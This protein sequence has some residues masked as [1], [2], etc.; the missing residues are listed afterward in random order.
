MATIYQLFGCLP[1]LLLPLLLPKLMTI[2]PTTGIGT[3][4]RPLFPGL[5][6]PGPDADYPLLVPMGDV[7]PYLG[8]DLGAVDGGGNFQL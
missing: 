3:K 1:I 5:L 2:L 8:L 7:L 4:G 6:I